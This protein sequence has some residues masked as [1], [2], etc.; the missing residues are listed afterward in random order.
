M[1]VI[2]DTSVLIALHAINQLEILKILFSR[3]IIPEGVF[4]EL[5]ADHRKFLLDDW[6]TIKKIGNLALY[7]SLL[8]KIDHGESEAITLA[9][10]EKADYILL[11][12]KEARK[13]AAN[14]GFKIIGTAGLL[15]LGK[16]KGLIDSVEKSLQKLSKTIHFRLSKKLRDRIIREAGE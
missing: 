7:N 5:S 8:L 11:D 2:S 9:I 13:V 16:K 15:L 6:I 12:D 4:N 14:L 1:T 10:E 3:I